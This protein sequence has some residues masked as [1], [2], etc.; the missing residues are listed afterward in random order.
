[1]I[2]NIP[3]LTLKDVDLDWEYPQAKDR[4]GQTADTENYVALARELKAA[5]GQKGL[6]MTLPTSFWYLQHFDVNSLQDS[7]DWFNLMSYVRPIP[8]KLDYFM[9]LTGCVRTFMESGISSRN[10]LVHTSLLILI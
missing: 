7:V 2:L 5:L 8:V 1:M 3:L 6:S 4:G 9:A 10:S